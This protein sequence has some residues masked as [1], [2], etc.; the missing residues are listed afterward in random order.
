MKNKVFP[1]LL[2]VVLQASAFQTV[3]KNPLETQQGLPAEKTIITGRVIA[4]DTEEPIAYASVGILNGSIGTISS[5]EGAFSLP[6]PAGHQEQTVRISALG[7]EAREIKVKDLLAMGTK[8]GLVTVALPSKPV[9]LAEVKV[10]PKNWVTKELGGTLGPNSKF[11][12]S[13]IINPRPIQ[14]NLGREIGIH[15]NNGQKLSFLSKLNFCL[16]SNRYDLVRFRLNVYDLKNGRPHQNL[17]PKDIY[18]TVKNRKTGWIQ[19]DLEPY[20]IYVEQD[21]V[22]SLEWIDCRPKTHSTSLSIPAAMPGLQTAFH[23]D[24]SQSKW[25]KIPAAGMGMNVLV[26][27]EK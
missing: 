13:F 10:S 16:K 4:Q 18:V 14:A 11:A 12:H 27:R 24:A 1:L 8:T 3:S 21:F 6:I 15:I 5:E 20:D 26:Q 2:L 25:Q 7:H 17:L 22:I 19:V 23:K 9:A